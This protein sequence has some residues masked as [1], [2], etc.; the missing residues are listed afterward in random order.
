MTRLLLCLAAGP[1]ATFAGSLDFTFK[2]V[3]AQVSYNGQL[4]RRADLSL[5]LLANAADRIAGGG[6]AGS[7]RYPNLMGF[8]SS[9]ALGFSHVESTTP[10]AV[11]IGSPLGSGPFRNTTVLLTSGAIVNGIFSLRALES[12]DR[13]SQIGPLRGPATANGPLTVLLKNGGTLSII[14]LESEPPYGN[15]SFEA[16]LVPGGSTP[17]ANTNHPP[18]RGILRKMGRK[19]L[20]LRT[21]G[22]VERFRLLAATSFRDQQGVPVRDS[23]LEPGDEL[24]VLVKPDDPETAAA[25]VLIR[26]KSGSRR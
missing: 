22:T 10:L 13:V 2:A 1:L 6:F 3:T 19:D 14:T 4:A 21:D 17:A 8:I 15:A 16:T 11:D 18:I 25:V 12:W 7:D 24:S 5:D 20:Y 26:R 9:Q 23:L